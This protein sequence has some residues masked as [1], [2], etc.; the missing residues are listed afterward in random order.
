MVRTIRDRINPVSTRAT[1]WWCHSALRGLVTGQ[2][3]YR[4]PRPETT[5]SAEGWVG[6]APTP[7]PIAQPADRGPLPPDLVG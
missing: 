3:L 4:M 1:D 6:F 7:G 5:D 2:R